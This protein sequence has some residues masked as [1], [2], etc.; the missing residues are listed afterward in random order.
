MIEYFRMKIEYLRSAGGG[1]IIKKNQRIPGGPS[2]GSSDPKE[3]VWWQAGGSYRPTEIKL[4][5]RSDIHKYSIYNLQSPL[6][7]LG[8]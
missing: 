2:L 3:I 4:T 5:E 7:G 8:A 1:S 6:S